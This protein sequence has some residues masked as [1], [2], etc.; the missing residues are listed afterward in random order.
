M[1]LFLVGS[2]T[3]KAAAL[4]ISI[5]RYQQSAVYRICKLID[6]PFL[7]F[8]YELYSNDFTMQ[9][10]RWCCVEFEHQST[11]LQCEDLARE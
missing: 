11:E 3:P 2:D 4:S 7:N 9:S 5:Q 10:A 8:Q 6:I 1:E